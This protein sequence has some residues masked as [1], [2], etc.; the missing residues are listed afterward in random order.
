METWTCNIGK[1]GRILR[2][3]VGLVALA[4]GI[5]LLIWSEHDFWATGL[6]TLGAFAI[7]EALKGWCALRA[8]G[9]QIPF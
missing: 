3:I 4:G 2:G 8:L 7:F 5:V 6:C 1:G 9:I